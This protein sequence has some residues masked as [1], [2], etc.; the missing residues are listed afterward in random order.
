ETRSREQGGFKG[1]GGSIRIQQRWREHLEVRHRLDSQ[2]DLQEIKNLLGIFSGLVE[3][4]P[5][6]SNAA[7]YQHRDGWIDE[8]ADQCAD[9]E[10]G[11]VARHKL[12]YNVTESHRHK[13]TANQKDHTCLPADRLFLR[14][15]RLAENRS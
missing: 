9:G 5:Q 13:V 14:L 11:A 6:S 10:R 1:V 15:F 2:E 8:C 7:D 12:A 4:Q 3:Q